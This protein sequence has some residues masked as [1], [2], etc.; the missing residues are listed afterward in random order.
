SWYEI[1]E[2]PEG[3]HPVPIGRAVANTQLYVLDGHLQPVPIGTPGEICIGGDGLAHGY[4]NDGELTAERFVPD[5]FNEDGCARLYKTG[6]IG[7]LRH[8]GNIEFLWRRDE[9]IKIR[10]FRVE[11]GEIQSTLN[12]SP[13]IRESLVV[14]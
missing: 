14:A 9:Q 1:T 11:P 2:P 13:L 6:D 8:D 7:R 5:P 4:V 3:E 12:T 10:G